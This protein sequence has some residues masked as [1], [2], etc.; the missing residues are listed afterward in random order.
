MNLT[1]FTK[2][3]PQQATYTQNGPVTFD[4]TTEE[5]DIDA[6]GSQVV[7]VMDNLTGPGGTASLG[8]SFRMGIFQ[9]LAVPYA[10]R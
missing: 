1:L 6:H 5:I 2:D 10:K 7:I 8:C 9:G 3:R 4:A